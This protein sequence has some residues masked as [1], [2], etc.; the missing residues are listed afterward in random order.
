MTIDN[1]V[2]EMCIWKTVYSHETD[3]LMN[4]NDM[5]NLKSYEGCIECSGYNKEC[6]KYYPIYK[7]DKGGKI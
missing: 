3:K 7:K 6:S 2:D 1:F 5:T 4:K